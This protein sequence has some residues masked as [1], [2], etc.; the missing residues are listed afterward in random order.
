MMRWSLPC[1][2][3]FWEPPTTSAPQNFSDSA[4]DQPWTCFGASS[5]VWHLWSAL[6]LMP[7]DDNSYHIFLSPTNVVDRFKSQTENFF[8]IP[9][10]SSDTTPV[11]QKA[12]VPC[13]LPFFRSPFGPEMGWGSI[14]DQGDTKRGGC[15]F[16]CFPGLKSPKS[17]ITGFTMQKGFL[18]WRTVQYGV[19][20]AK[21]SA[22]LSFCGSPV[23][24][25]FFWHAMAA[26]FP[27]DLIP[28]TKS[29]LPSTCSWGE[30]RS[31]CMHLYQHTATSGSWH[32]IIPC[33]RLLHPLS[34]FLL[35]PLDI[36]IIQGCGIGSHIPGINR[37]TNIIYK[38]DNMGLRTNFLILKFSRKGVWGPIIF[39]W[40]SQQ[41]M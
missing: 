12:E 8:G 17:F 13:P 2:C 4:P 11:D 5:C 25:F 6:I 28:Q 33:L 14:M 19:G 41:A 21:Q 37:I 32:Q 18:R 35:G 15:V 22:S 39:V 23:V 10:L 26:P 30:L 29:E 24:G 16:V 20:M 9:T 38:L 3:A 31:N 1:S 27:V 36:S 40:S 7:T 34:C